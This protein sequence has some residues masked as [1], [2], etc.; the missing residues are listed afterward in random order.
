MLT[1]LPCACAYT[2]WVK[3]RAMDPAARTRI[4]RAFVP[5]AVWSGAGGVLAVIMLRLTRGLGAAKPDLASGLAYAVQIGKGAGPDDTVFVPFWFFVVNEFFWDMLWCGLAVWLCAA[6][7]R[8]AFPPRKP[9][10]AAVSAAP[11]TPPVE[12]P[13]P[14]SRPSF[15]FQKRPPS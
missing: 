2:A 5:F 13:A 1:F 14:P 15:A 10:A 7:F 3:M 9:V 4:A 12:P 8:I 11:P 6:A